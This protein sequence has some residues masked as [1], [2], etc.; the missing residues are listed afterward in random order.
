MSLSRQFIRF[1]AVGLCGT[2]VQYVVLWG[3]VEFFGTPAALASGVGYMCGSVVN[4]LLNYFFTF[5]SGKTHAEAASKYFSVLAVGWCINTGLMAVLVHS[6]GWNYWIAQ[7]LT[8]GI[9]LIWNFAGSRL[10]AFKEVRG[11][12]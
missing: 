7:I 4:Y 6:M 3:G 11:Q 8:T 2:A 10:W 12:S 1:A 5:E 9:G